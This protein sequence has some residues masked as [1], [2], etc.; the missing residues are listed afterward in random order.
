MVAVLSSIGSRALETGEGVIDRFKNS[1]NEEIARLLLK[2]GAGL[3]IGGFAMGTVGYFAKAASTAAANNES[4]ILGNFG[5]IFS[6]I[7]APQ[8]QPAATGTA[9]LSFSVEGIQNFASD[10]GQ[11]IQAAGSDIAQIGAI[12][13]TLGEDVAAGFIDVAKALLAF[14]MHF[15]D[16]LWN[17]LVWGIGGAIA[18]ILDWLFPWVV[19]L[20]VFCIISGTILLIADRSWG[21]V[22]KP[23]WERASGK[24]AAR[25]EARLEA[26][27]D[28]VFGNFKH[29]TKEAVAPVPV[30]EAL[31]SP[32]SPAAGPATVPE[33]VSGGE[34]SSA[35]VLTKKPPATEITSGTTFGA[36]DSPPLRRLR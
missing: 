12:M 20:G 1:T 22:A 2:A 3:V 27:F 9:P 34:R 23:A 6:N 5:T 14:V 24:W 21:L 26:G 16:L 25:Q 28:R 32:P 31:P 19:L 13:G 15:P 35:P 4:N 17:G 36:P 30:P 8:F 33:G 10:I 11:D 18:D 29:E 7:Q